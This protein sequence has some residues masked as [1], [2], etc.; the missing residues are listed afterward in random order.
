M[1]ALNELPRASTN[2]SAPAPATARKNGVTGT[3][4]E[5]GCAVTPWTACP[6]PPL[7]PCPSAS[8]T[9]VTTWTTRSYAPHEHP[10][11]NERGTRS[12]GVMPGFSK[13]AA[14]AAD[15]AAGQKG[16]GAASA[17]EKNTE[18]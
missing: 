6:P 1:K 17:A 2:G 12:R 4:A 3:G 5:E 8:Q 10:C 16:E 14:R 15:A 13:G 9:W 7:P 18:A 11:P